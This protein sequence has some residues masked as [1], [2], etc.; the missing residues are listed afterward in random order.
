ME[1]IKAL[2]EEYA[3]QDDKIKESDEK[4]YTAYKKV[5]ETTQGECCCGSLAALCCCGL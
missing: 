5:S 4:V 2:L 3:T 1:D